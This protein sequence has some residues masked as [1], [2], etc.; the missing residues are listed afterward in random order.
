MPFLPGAGAGGCR[1]DIRRPNAATPPACWTPTTTPGP[2]RSTPPTARNAQQPRPPRLRAGRPRGRPRRGLPAPPPAVEEPAG[3]T[4][5]PGVLPGGGRG[6][7]SAAPGRP[8]G[9]DRPGQR[10]EHEETSAWDLAGEALVPLLWGLSGED[11][12]EVRVTGYGT[13][14]DETWSEYG[15]AATTPG[16]AL[17]T[18]PD[19][20]ARPGRPGGPTALPC[21]GVQAAAPDRLSRSA[22]HS[23]A[24]RAPSRSWRRN[25]RQTRTSRRKP[26]SPAV[27]PTCWSRTATPGG[28]RAGRTTVPRSDTSFTHSKGRPVA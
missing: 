17:R 23:P 25:R 27:S 6:G 2:V 21:P 1:A 8:G 19:E 12:R 11:E 5:P 14:E 15:S 22:R 16:T 3:E 7:G 9:G 18:E 28:A 4:A 20:D 13:E 26:G 10:G 24:R